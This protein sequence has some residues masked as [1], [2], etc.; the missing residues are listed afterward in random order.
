MNFGPPDSNT[1][2]SGSACVSGDR[3]HQP[4]PSFVVLMACLYF[5]GC[6]TVVSKHRIPCLPASW[7]FHMF[8]NP[9]V[10]AE[11]AQGGHDETTR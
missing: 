10:L 8:P 3:M 1:S 11:P 5:C 7:L 9:D 6:F 2:K 4:E